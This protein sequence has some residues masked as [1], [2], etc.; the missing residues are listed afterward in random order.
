LPKQLPES[1]EAEVELELQLAVEEEVQTSNEA[2]VNLDERMTVAAE[3]EGASNTTENGA[4]SN[5]VE[6]EV[7]NN[8]TNEADVHGRMPGRLPTVTVKQLSKERIAA[9]VGSTVTVAAA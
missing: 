2:E 1:D 3:N 9:L 5:P 8:T 6:V 4:A 7:H